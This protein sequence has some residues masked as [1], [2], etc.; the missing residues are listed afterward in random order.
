MSSSLLIWKQEPLSPQNSEESWV[1]D[2]DVLYWTTLEQDETKVEFD[3]DVCESKAEVASKLLNDLDQLEGLDEWIKEE[4]P[5][6]NWLEEKM[7]PIFDDVETSQASAAMPI[8]L[9]EIKKPVIP[10]TQSLLREFETVFDAVEMTHGTLTPPQS[11]PYEPL[12]IT[13]EPIS[14]SSP[15]TI[16]AKPNSYPEH[17]KQILITGLDFSNS[18]VMMPMEYPPA[19][20]QPDVARELAVVDELVRSR[21]E[22]MVQ[23]P[24]SPSSSSCSSSS[25]FGDYSSDDPEWIPETISPDEE[26][27]ENLLKPVSR[28]RSKPYS[29]SSPEDKKSRKKEQNKNAATRYRLKK[30]AETEE[31]LEEER[32]VMKQNDV[33][34]NQ[35]SDLQREIKYLKGLMR[36]LFKA[37]GLVN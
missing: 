4:E 28:K 25:N 17:D 29:R 30:K 11:P 26:Q 15:Y 18:S 33:L 23:S 31:I 10:N 1:P 19:T 7:L 14:V 37:K 32:L 24:S 6:S 2:D 3:F 27:S 36:D 13:L 21:V 12:L 34:E 16:T 20:P 9:E 5:F 22:D 35:I 8:K